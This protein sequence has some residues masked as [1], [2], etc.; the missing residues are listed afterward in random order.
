MIHLINLTLSM[1]QL[2]RVTFTDNHDEEMTKKKLLIFA[3]FSSLGGFCM[4]FGLGRSMVEET[5]FNGG[6]WAISGLLAMQTGAN[7]ARFFSHPP[8]QEILRQQR[9]T[10]NI[11]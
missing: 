1:I 5:S 6:M 3:L 9:P 7:L 2:C 10:N 8:T 11:R 4:P